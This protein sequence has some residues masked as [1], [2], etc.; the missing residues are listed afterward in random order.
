MRIVNTGFGTLLS[1]T[2]VSLNRRRGSLGS[3]MGMDFTTKEFTKHKSS[4]KFFV[5]V[6][7]SLTYYDVGCVP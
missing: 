4:M 7:P 2:Y 1:T 6:S 3:K 5:D